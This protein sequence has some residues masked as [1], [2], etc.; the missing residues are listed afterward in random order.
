MLGDNMI[1]YN[2]SRIV[3]HVCETLSIPVCVGMGH[4]YLTGMHREWPKRRY[5][6]YVFSPIPVGIFVLS[7]HCFNVPRAHHLYRL[8]VR[9][10]HP[11]G[12]QKAI[13]RQGPN[14]AASK[15]TVR[16]IMSLFVPYRWLPPELLIPSPVRMNLHNR[17]TS[18]RKTVGPFDLYWTLFYA[19]CTAGVLAP[20][21]SV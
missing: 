15:P 1:W 12:L 18:S 17:W 3:G 4:I 19:K 16:W 7:P 2:N 11:E 14:T 10:P 13:S 5:V 9:P 20:P 21:Q 8:Y 6:R